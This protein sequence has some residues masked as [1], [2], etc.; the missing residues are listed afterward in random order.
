M[1]KQDLERLREKLLRQ[2]EEVF[3][4]LHDLDKGWQDLGG[5]ESEFEEEAQK[6]ELAKLFARL[7]EREQQEIE[8]INLALSK[9]AA[10]TYGICDGCRKPI[11]L[12]RLE[13]L[14]ATPY[15]LD[16]AI[17]KE[18]KMKMPPVVP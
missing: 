10:A 11:S 9:M 18:G 5:H 15:C 6:A 12:A 4:G 8:E 16:C 3:Q 1:M 2:R 7:D 17:K 13:A 14:P